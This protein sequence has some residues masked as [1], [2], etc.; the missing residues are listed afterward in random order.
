MPC[1]S[2]DQE[3]EG[4]RTVAL[5]TIPLI[6]ASPLDQRKVVYVKMLTNS[7]HAISS[8]TPEAK[9]ARTSAF[10]DQRIE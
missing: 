5:R 8:M 3:Q 6:D 2:A 1:L 7:Q 10:D 9:A 4:Y